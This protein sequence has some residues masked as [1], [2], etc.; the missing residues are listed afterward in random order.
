MR[1]GPKEE[2][3]Q[4][5]LLAMAQF[6]TDGHRDLETESAQWTDSVKSLCHNIKCAVSPASQDGFQLHPR[7]YFQG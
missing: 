6:T 2:D 3:L 5:Q 4:K 7:E 1:D